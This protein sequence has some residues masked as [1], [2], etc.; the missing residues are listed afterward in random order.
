MRRIET[1]LM[2]AV[3]GTGQQ[4]VQV[5]PGNW[6]APP[7]SSWSSR[8]GNETAEVFGVEGRTRRP[9]KHAGRNVSER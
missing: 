2:C 9:R 3:N 6:I 8:E 1:V 5:P 4:W 7:G